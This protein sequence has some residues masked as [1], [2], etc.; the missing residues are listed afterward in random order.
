MRKFFSMV[1]E[2]LGQDYSAKERNLTR[3]MFSVVFLF[4]ICNTLYYILYF[5]YYFDLLQPSDYIFVRAVNIFLLTI[6]SS[7]NIIF[8]FLYIK[9]FR[10]NL[11]ALFS[12]PKSNP[13]KVEAE[14]ISLKTKSGNET[15]E[16][17][18]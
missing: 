6:N 1:K 8:Y 4:I 16:T 12:L 17:K 3:M 5:A 18:Y 10:T 14:D 11:L 13:N 7:I 2:N 15:G 9:S